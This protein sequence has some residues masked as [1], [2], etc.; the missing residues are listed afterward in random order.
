MWHSR[1]SVLGVGTFLTGELFAAELLEGLLLGRRISKYSAV[2]RLGQ[3]PDDVRIAVLHA[4]HAS[5][6][7]HLVL[8]D[9][10]V[11]AVVLRPDFGNVQPHY[12]F[13]AVRQESNR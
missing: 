2:R 4:E 5:S 6:D 12:R 1:H 8:A 11:F 7:A 10:V 13:V 9:A 3:R